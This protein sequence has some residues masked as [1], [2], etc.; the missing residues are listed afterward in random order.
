MGSPAGNCFPVSDRM[1]TTERLTLP[2][3][4]TMLYESTTEDPVVG[5]EPVVSLDFARVPRALG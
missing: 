4:D 5:D 2:N 1:K 3:K